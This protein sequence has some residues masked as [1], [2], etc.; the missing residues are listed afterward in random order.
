MTDTVQSIWVHLLSTLLLTCVVTLQLWD[1]HELVVQLNVGWW[2][3]APSHSHC[4]LYVH[5]MLIWSY[6]TVI[7]YPVLKSCGFYQRDAMLARVFVT[8]T[9]PSVCP[10]VCHTPVLCLAERK[11]VVKCTPSDSPMTLVSG[12]YDSSK[13]SQGVTPKERTKWGWVGFFRRFST[14]MSSTHI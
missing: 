8:A 4:I 14:N 12:R 10:D 13:N 7:G 5:I 11:Q 6:I 1:K 3:W 2:L 9:C